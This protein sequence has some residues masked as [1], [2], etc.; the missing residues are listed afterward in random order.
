MNL[1]SIAIAAVEQGMAPDR[2]TRLAIH[3][4]CRQRLRETEA[5]SFRRSAD[6]AN[7]LK[8]LYD[9]PIA[10]QPEKAN[11]Q[12]YELPA[13]FFQLLLGPRLKYSC[14]YW[15]DG[16]GSLADA[17][18]A[19]LDLTCQRADLQ[20]GQDILELG[21]G[22]G[23][24]SMWMAERYPA[25]RV[26]VVSNSAPQRQFIESTATRL[27]LTNLRVV[28]ADMNHFAPQRV[29]GD[30]R[31]D[32]I[33]SVE[34]FEHMRNYNL[35]LARVGAWL[36][37]D[38][39]LFVHHFCHRQWSYPFET[40]GSADWMGRY[41]FTGG[42]MPGADLL[43]EF[44]RNLRVTEE[45]NWNGLHYQR[46]AQ[47]WLANLD[48]CRGDALDILKTAYGDKD[49]RRW[50][51]RWRVFLM[52]VAELFG[53]GGGEEWFVA[54]RLLQPSSIPSPQVRPCLNSL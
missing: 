50:F 44:D 13:E 49:A 12:H 10:H 21:C 11:E 27:R 52:A 43:R 32:R 51:G 7:F 28:T 16:G 18:N 36:R 40:R 35:L 2:V 25:S 53:Y 30:D 45:W 54:H 37:P 33:V 38:G 42:M 9:G 17:E 31:F 29:T 19:A 39:K 41:F 48:A 4:L 34:M 23:S 22:W 8:S 14:C 5:A 3:R 15:P 1:L 24:L 47:A 6:R 26:T 20:D 46:T